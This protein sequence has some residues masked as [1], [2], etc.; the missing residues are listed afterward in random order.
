MSTFSTA[1]S[2]LTVSTSQD[3]AGSVT[4]QEIFQHP[5]DNAGYYE[6]KH[7]GISSAAGDTVSAISIAIQYLNSQSGNYNTVATIG[8]GALGS[9]AANSVNAIPGIAGGLNSGYAVDPSP[10]SGG[11]IRFKV[12]PNMRVVISQTAAG[13]IRHYFS[14]THW[15]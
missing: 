1:L 10:T 2:Q 12:Y 6:F 13:T 7:H 14:H 3:V 15:L 9:V 4:D 5:N 8:S 11:T